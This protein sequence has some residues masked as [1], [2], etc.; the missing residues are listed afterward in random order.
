MHCNHISCHI[1]LTRPHSTSPSNHWLTWRHCYD[2]Y[3]HARRKDEKSSKTSQN[4]FECILL[5]TCNFWYCKSCAKTR[6][7]LFK[8]HDDVELGNNWQWCHPLTSSV[9]YR[10]TI[11]IIYKFAV[12]LCTLPR[13]HYTCILLL[14]CNPE[15]TIFITE[16]SIGVSSNASKWNEMQSWVILTFV[17]SEQ[18]AVIC[19]WQLILPCRICRTFSYLVCKCSSF[20]EYATCSLIWK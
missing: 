10:P 11:L 12:R 16:I 7:K 14:R 20:Y 13:S 5:C 4:I 17:N 1:F 3:A 18:R 2:D 6:P 9:G 15:Q 8:R 19:C